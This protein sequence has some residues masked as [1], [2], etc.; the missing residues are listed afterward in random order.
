[1][2]RSKSWG[3]CGLW[4]TLER[5]NIDRNGRDVLEETG[6][7]EATILKWTLKRKRRCCWLHPAGTP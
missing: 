6:F 1:M 4:H 5:I 3:G 7:D 2:A